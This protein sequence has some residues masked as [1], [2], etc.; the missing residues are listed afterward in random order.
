[1]TSVSD[2]QHEKTALKCVVIGDTLAGK[3]AFIKVFNQEDF[4]YDSPVTILLLETPCSFVR[5]SVRPSRFLQ[6]G[7]TART[8]PAGA[9]KF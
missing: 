8:F 6:A 9:A 2:S 3:T 7:T 5:S 4:P 1:M